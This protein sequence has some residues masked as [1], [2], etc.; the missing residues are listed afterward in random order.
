MHIDDIVI[1]PKGFFQN[2][3]Y[4]SMPMA[5]YLSDPNMPYQYLL[6]S[7]ALDLQQTPCGSLSSEHWL[8]PWKQHI[9]DT[10]ILA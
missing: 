3:P 2:I 6:N 8:N 5:D 9:Q 10:S 7:P 4:F 1:Y